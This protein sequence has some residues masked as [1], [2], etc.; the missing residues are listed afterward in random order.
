MEGVPIRRARRIVRWTLALALIVQPSDGFWSHPDVFDPAAST[1]REICIA[2]LTGAA[3]TTVAVPLGLSDGLNVAA[4][5]ADVR[6]DPALMMPV[7][8]RLGADTQAVGGW[9]VDSQTIGPGLLRVLGY[10]TPPVGLGSDFKQ[11]AIV[12]FLIGPGGA[13]GDN[14]LPLMSCILGDPNALS[15][16]CGLCVQPGIAFAEPRFAFSLVDDALGFRPNRQFV[17]QGD[18]VLW[19]NV[20]SFQS[21]TSTSGTSCTADGLWNGALSPG[22]QFARRFVEPPGTLPYFCQPHCPLG[23]TGEVVV[24]PTI[25]LSL[26]EAAGLLL[27]TWDGGSGFYRVFRS[28]NPAFVGSGTES[29]TPDAGD[30]GQSFS[31]T[32]QTGPGGA[33]FYLVTSKN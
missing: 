1:T 24:T 6:F 19:K 18:W 31:D 25:Q 23:E 26:S 9:T 22:A 21:H 4:F 7:R 12:D 10:S 17:E 2:S 30:T 5:Q 13:A 29:F 3:D 32:A 8:A 33:L 20:G 15:L 28:D 16:P 14:P 11:I 27:L